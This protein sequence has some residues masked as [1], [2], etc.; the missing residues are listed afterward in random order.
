MNL[1]FDPFGLEAERDTGSGD[2]VAKFVDNNRGY[3]RGGVFE[4]TARLDGLLIATAVLPRELI[5]DQLDATS[6]LI[7]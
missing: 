6:A 7:L 1:P 3:L 5:N 4:R 2:F